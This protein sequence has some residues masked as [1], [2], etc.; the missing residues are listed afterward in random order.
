MSAITGVL[1]IPFLMKIKSFFENV[2]ESN[3]V[4]FD[5]NIPKNI[6]FRTEL[7]CE[8]VQEEHDYN[9]NLNNFLMLLYLDFVKTSIKT[10]NPEKV[11]Q[12]LS[13]DFFETDLLISNGSESCNIKR[14]NFEFSNITISIAR[15]DY[16]KGQ[17]IL[18]ELYDI[19]K[20]KFSF[21]HLI[22]ALWLD[23]IE[24]YK[25]GSKKRAYYSIIN[26]LK[27]CFES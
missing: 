13:K 22:E 26:L 9:F 10:Y 16:L 25:T 21:S 8:Y 14:N 20:C 4:I 23:F 6:L 7:I 17:L 18:D 27:D 12:L 5:V 3:E 24:C 1:N 11:F 15:K 19:Y 2:S